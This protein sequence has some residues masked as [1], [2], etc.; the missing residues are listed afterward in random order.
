MKNNKKY[1]KSLKEF[2]SIDIPLS[3]YDLLICF[4]TMLEKIIKDDRSNHKNT[5][6]KKQKI[7]AIKDYLYDPNTTFKSTSE[8]INKS[9]TTVRYLVYHARGEFLRLYRRTKLKHYNKETITAIDII[10]NL[11]EGA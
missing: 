11:K 6:T 2:I 5:L 9:R 8:Q 1:K 4:N 10:N 3:N 7:W